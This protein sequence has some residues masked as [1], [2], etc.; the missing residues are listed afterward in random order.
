MQKINN[1][2]IVFSKKRKKLKVAD[3]IVKSA[4]FFLSSIFYLN[5]FDVLILLAPI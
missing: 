1:K 3:L 2:E 5:S 4:T